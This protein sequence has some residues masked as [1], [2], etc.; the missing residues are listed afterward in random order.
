M[1]APAVHPTPRWPAVLRE[2]FSTV[3]IAARRDVAL[4][5]LLLAAMMVLLVMIYLDDPR[6]N[7]DFVPQVAFPA[8]LLGFLAPM[9][10][11][12]GEE[13]S[14]RSYF[15]A[16]P[17]DRARHTLMKTLDGWAWFMVLVGT[18]LLWALAMAVLTGGEIG[19]EGTRVPMREGVRP[20]DMDFHTFW[21][22]IPAWQWLTPF[23]G[24][25]I[26]YLLG[27]IVVLSSDHPWRWFAGILFGF[28]LLV[29]LGEA[30][31]VSWL[32]RAL[33]SVVEGRLG[34]EPAISGTLDTT[35]TLTTPAGRS[36]ETI[37][38]MP[39]L[40]AWLTAMPFWL[41]LGAVGVAVAAYRHQER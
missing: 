17:V 21:W 34:L 5:A 27:S 36:V 30:G 4:L 33:R 16:M 24:A 12:K 37:R 25:T 23:T 15:W 3:G 28:F 18:Y 14:R 26:A 39:A 10:V 13:P 22:R 40:R 31:D 9:A 2:Q 29:S 41:A 32:E 1:D 11:W 8:I 19:V 7:F 35:Q 20:T 6:D 38:S